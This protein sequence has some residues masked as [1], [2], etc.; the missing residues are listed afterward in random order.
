[1]HLRDY[2]T[3][4]KDNE[5]LLTGV[6]IEKLAKGRRH[7]FIQK[8]VDKYVSRGLMTQ[9]DTALILHTIDGDMV[10]NI[11]HPPTRVCLTC[12]EH[13][14]NEDTAKGGEAIPQGDP[15]LGAAARKH[16]AEKHPGVAS[17]DP[18]HPSGYKYKKYYGVTPD[19]SVPTV[20]PKARGSILAAVALGA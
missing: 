1:M 5:S 14:T 4:N 16:M 17:P 13:L 12:G 6:R 11:D 10:F 9:S 18:Q 3:Q 15:R 20:N 7:H 2:Y 8:T 19:D